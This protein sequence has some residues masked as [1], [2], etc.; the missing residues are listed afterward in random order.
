MARN[1]GNKTFNKNY[2][3]KGKRFHGCLNKKPDNVKKKEKDKK[4]T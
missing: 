3:G 2:S 1:N 4:S